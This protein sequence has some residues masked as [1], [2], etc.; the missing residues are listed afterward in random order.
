MLV[1][2][3]VC[4]ESVTVEHKGETLRVRILHIKQGRVKLG[5]QGDK[6]FEVRRSELPPAKTVGGKV[7]EVA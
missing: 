3:R 1:L 4:E 2:S 6:S 5:F 7:D